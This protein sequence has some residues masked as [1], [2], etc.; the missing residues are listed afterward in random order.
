[1]AMVV[2][3]SHTGG[4]STVE[5]QVPTRGSA[6]DLITFADG[7]STVKR[8]VFVVGTDKAEVSVPEVSI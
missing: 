1:V 8:N 4:M 3:G 5:D 7:F 6:E 2:S